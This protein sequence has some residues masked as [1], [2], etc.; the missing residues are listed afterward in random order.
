M[1][2]VVDIETTGGHARLHR[3]I[4]IAVLLHDGKKVT[5]RFETLL[6]PGTGI[7][8]FI[9]GLTGIKP[10]M[11]ADSPTFEEIASTIYA[12]L[13]D[14]VFVAHNVSFDYPFVRDALERCGLT[15]DVPRLCTVRAS[16][17]LI[18]GLSSYSLG[19]MTDALSIPIVHRH[20]AFGDAAATAELL[21]RLIER[22]E[23]GYLASLYHK[24][25]R[26]LELPPLLAPEVLDQLPEET[27]VY[28]FHDTTGRVMYVGKA[29]DIR[30][31]VKSHFTGQSDFRFEKFFAESLA[32]I[33]FEVTGSEL[34]ASLLESLEIRRLWPKYNYAGKYR[35]QEYGLCLFEDQAGYL[36]LSVTRPMKGTKLV[37][38]LGFK[39][40]A[41]EVILDL[42]EQQ[43]LCAN[44]CHIEHNRSGCSLHQTGQCHGACLGKEP[45]ETYNERVLKGLS[46]LDQSTPSM[47]LLDRGRHPE[48]QALIWIENGRFSGYRFLSVDHVF[49]DWDDATELI[50][51]VAPDPELDRIVA[52]FITKHTYKTVL[53]S[54]FT[55]GS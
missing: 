39:S 29:V 22:D 31:R 6:N 24:K 36:H 50:K 13:S 21:T 4:E 27:G 10:G 16:R 35:R 30:R 7:P 44:L 54:H 51:Q 20:R 8:S 34:V 49:S 25:Q 37:K 48:E 1:Y 23:G 26:K 55:D 18:P 43:Q 38:T 52:Q 11:L 19:R 12:L 2:A 3:I 14:R 9:Q 40:K 33:S 42:L 5:D 41:Q 53:R 45:P 15:L 17:K 47:L 46:L 28:Y 32:D